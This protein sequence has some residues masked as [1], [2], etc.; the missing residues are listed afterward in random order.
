MLVDVVPD[1]PL[2]STCNPALVTPDKPFGSNELV[3]V[4][5]QCLRQGNVLCKEVY[6][7][8]KIVQFGNEGVV[9]VRHSLRRK[10]SDDVIVPK[11]VAKVDRATDVMPGGTATERR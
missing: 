8:H 7:V 9:A 4:E 2:V 11:Y 3:D 10:I 6:F 5:F 1:V